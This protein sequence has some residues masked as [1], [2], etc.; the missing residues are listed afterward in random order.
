MK[1][2]SKIEGHVLFWLDTGSSR[3][4]LLKHRESYTEEEMNT[5]ID[6][7]IADGTFTASS[8]QDWLVVTQWLP[9]T[10]KRMREGEK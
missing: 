8:K 4:V 2:L 7:L 9:N 3:V 1:K 10:A 5:A 6:G